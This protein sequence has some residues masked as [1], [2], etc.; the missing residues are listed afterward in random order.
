MKR[1][2]I[3]R[4]AINKGLFGLVF[5]PLFGCEGGSKVKA[6][7]KS[8]HFYGVEILTTL[9]PSQ[10]QLASIKGELFVLYPQLLKSSNQSDLIDTINRL[11][12]SDFEN[13]LIVG[14]NNQEFSRLESLI[15]KEVKTGEAS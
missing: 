9:S 10:Q 3:N 14:F 13:D 2:T 8:N 6:T 5:L 11:I 15:Y 1:R 12:L 7:L 4:R